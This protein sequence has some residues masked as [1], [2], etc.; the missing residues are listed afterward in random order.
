MGAGQGGMPA[1]RYFGLGGKPA[2]VPVR[3]LLHQECGF[4]QVV[5]GGDLL[6]QAVAEPGVQ[7]IDHRRI[8]AEGPAAEGV[9]LMKFELHG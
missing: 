1:Q 5:L 4:R 2:D 3:A 9:D 7:P 6:H 8:A